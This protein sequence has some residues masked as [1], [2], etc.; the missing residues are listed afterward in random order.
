MNPQ[1]SITSVE[2][3]AP[4]IVGSLLQLEG[5]A[6]PVSQA[7]QEQFFAGETAQCIEKF[8]P[9]QEQVKI[10]D[11]PEVQVLQRIQEQQVGDIPPPPIYRG[12]DSGGANS[13][14]D[15]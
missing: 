13:R 1:F 15:P 4:Q 5:H 11:F 3:S 2:A 14:A 9:V 7:H 8:Q 12:R 10:Q 6:A